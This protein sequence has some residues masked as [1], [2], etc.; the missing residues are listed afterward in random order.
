MIENN[1]ENVHNDPD[2]LL[3]VVFPTIAPRPVNVRTS[4]LEEAS[5]II[6]GEREKNYG[7][8]EENLG[9]IRDYWNTY[10]SS[11]LGVKTNIDNKD[12]ALLMTLLKIARASETPNHDTFVDAIGYVA[13][14]AEQVE[15]RT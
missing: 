10:L 8:P 13:L 6:N 15:N 1:P 2:T 11:R 14:A 7:P 5:D 12:V 9:R 4:I 3:G